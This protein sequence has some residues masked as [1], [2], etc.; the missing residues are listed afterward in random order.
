MYVCM[1][2]YTWFVYSHFIP[3]GVAKAFHIFFRDTF[4]KTTHHQPI[5]VPT[6]GAQAFLMDYPQG[7]KK[8]KRLSYEEYCRRD[9]WL[10]HPCLITAYIRCKCCWSFSRI[11]RHP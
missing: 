8:A 2:V 11:L 6:A 5:N 1:Y 9:R 10:A 3:K 7:E 4:T